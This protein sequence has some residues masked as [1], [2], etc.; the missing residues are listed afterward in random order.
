[1]R[2]S[3]NGKICFK[4]QLECA[5]IKKDKEGFREHDKIETSWLKISKG[6]I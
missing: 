5:S 2:R 4:K 6:I 1:M 3:C